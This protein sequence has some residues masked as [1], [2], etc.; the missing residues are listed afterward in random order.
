MWSDE[1]NGS[2]DIERFFQQILTGSAIFTNTFP[3]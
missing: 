1:K 3:A 2:Q